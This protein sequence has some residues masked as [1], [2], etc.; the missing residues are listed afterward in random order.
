MRVQVR[1]FASLAERTGCRTESLELKDGTLHQGRKVAESPTTIGFRT[2]LNRVFPFAIAG[3]IPQDRSVAQ[4]INV[5]ALPGIV[6]YFFGNDPAKWRTDVP[7]YRTVVY[8][9]IY[10]RGY[11]GS[12]SGVRRYIG[13]QRRGTKKRKGDMPLELQAKLLQ[14]LFH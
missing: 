7:N 4:L 1:Y 6:N 13:L 3:N 5:A 12:E 8:E 2:C 9:D 14:V 10:E 11:R